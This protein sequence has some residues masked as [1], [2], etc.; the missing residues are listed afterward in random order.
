M[1]NDETNEFDLDAILAEVKELKKSV[2]TTEEPETTSAR[3]W[4]SQDVDRLILSTRRPSEPGEAVPEEADYSIYLQNDPEPQ[5]EAEAEISENEARTGRDDAERSKILELH[6]TGLIPIVEPDGEPEIRKTVP[7]PMPNPE[8][9]PKKVVS[10]NIAS[11]VSPSD[12]DEDI[13]PLDTSEYLSGMETDEVR[14]RFL[15]ILEL[16]KT[17]EH[18]VYNVNDPI[19]KPG[20]IL[21]KN[22]F[23]KTSDLD[24]MPLVIPAEEALR[25]A[26]AEEKTI[27]SGA[28]PVPGA[29]AKEPDGV[30]DGQIVLT[31]FENAE[32][33]TEKVSEASVE[34]ALYARRK[35]KAKNFTLVGIPE[36]GDAPYQPASGFESFDG[37]GK[38]KPDETEST[39]PPRKKKLEYRFP[40][41]RSR[42]YASIKSAVTRSTFSSVVLFIIMIA[43]ALLL[44][45][46]ALFKTFSVDS[47]VF[48]ANGKAYLAASFL[49]LAVAAILNI[50]CII[51]G[52][53]ALFKLKPNCDSGVALAVL[54]AAVQNLLVMFMP[55]SSGVSAI[56]SAAA[57]FA[58]LLN[59]FGR[60]YSHAS[61][62]DNFE[63]CAFTSPQNLY[64]IKEVENAT[65]AFEIGRG[66]LMG[67][68]AVAYSCKTEFP[69]DFIENARS[70]G[71]AE[72]FSVYQV[73]I[74]SGLSLVTGL[75]A[76]GLTK[77]FMQGF[78]VFTGA[79]CLGVPA[80][81]F[82]ASSYPLRAANKKLN[83]SGAMIANQSSAEE[84][85]K[86]NAV[87]IDS[88]DIFDRSRCSMHGMKEFKNFR[89]DDVVLY[90]A[91]III[92]SGGPLTDI[93]DKVIAGNRE[94]LPPVKTLSYEDRSGLT[95]W[96]HNQ[97][98]FLGNRNMLVNHS[99]DVP[100]KGDEDK[101]KHDG[102]RVMY[103]AINNKIAAMFVVSYAADSALLP[104][105]KSLENNGMQLL[106]RT[107]DSNITEDLLADC[108]DLPVN[109]V[110]VISATAGRIFKR[111]RDRVNETAPARVLHDGSALSLLKSIATASSLSLCIR[112]AQI[113]Q[114]VSIGLGLLGLLLLVLISKENII[115]ALQI[116]VFQAFWAVAAL[117]AGFVKKVK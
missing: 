31:G 1:N 89:I 82:L 112:I 60:R 17:A 7:D 113:I 3:T 92:K 13:T 4:T 96:I 116:I 110:K 114:T 33:E 85:A 77:N 25:N 20:V 5:P 95:A 22:R 69:S 58:L 38:D 70:V 102:R 59:A 56:F 32:P 117:A 41:Q 11:P 36:E 83:V 43:F 35:E 18:D 57:A 100:P 76:W 84:A 115:G 28:Q 94:L 55:Q 39:P 54:F 109:N 30:V 49:L 26:I 64:S 61:A 101:Y 99:I 74:A 66:I 98:V 24:P 40:E 9:S 80:C 62:L 23:S 42:I 91:A 75:I 14:E 90:T 53:K 86:R 48:A 45:L 78:S 93:F 73:P 71:L 21:E 72:I 51:S 29:A 107:C 67:N 65:E 68:P 63:F 104:Y 106:V 81:A 16:E 37:G 108:F 47:A 79:M 103:L 105:I 50:P 15:N 27:I 2:V 12:F 19:E 88:A 34:T 52:Y 87:V 10:I 111:Y 6:R 97:K 8:A 46:P 44:A